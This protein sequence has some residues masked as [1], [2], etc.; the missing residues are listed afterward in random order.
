M[1]PTHY[2]RI[3]TPEMLLLLLVGGLICGT[4]WRPRQQ[5]F[6]LPS[7]EPPH[8]V[9]KTKMKQEKDA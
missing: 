1:S 5:P 6:S 4:V 9:I 2:A 8:N 7:R 3:Y